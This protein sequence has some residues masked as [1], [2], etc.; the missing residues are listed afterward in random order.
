MTA[1]SEVL[2]GKVLY[3]QAYSFYHSGLYYKARDCFRVL[4]AVEPGNYNHW[5]GLGA[6]LQMIREYQDAIQAYSLSALADLDEK[7]PFPHFHA[8]ECLMAI[9]K[10]DRAIIALNSAEAIAKQQKSPQQLLNQIEQLR[11]ATL[12][13]KDK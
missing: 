9:R 1:K 12:E 10:Y 3:S 7:D 4:T 6:T 8:A 13:I 5:F 11:V 2:D